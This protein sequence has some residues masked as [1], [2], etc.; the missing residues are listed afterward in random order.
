MINLTRSSESIFNPSRY[1]GIFILKC[2][3]RVLKTISV[4]LIAQFYSS[5]TDTDNT[6]C[7]STTQYTFNMKK[8]PESFETNEKKFNKLGLSKKK[9]YTPIL[10]KNKIHTFAHSMKNIHKK[11]YLN[12]LET[13]F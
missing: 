9:L 13:F 4:K 2:A 8:I 11:N 3:L 10:R 7:L 5:S 1:T 6:L 12:I